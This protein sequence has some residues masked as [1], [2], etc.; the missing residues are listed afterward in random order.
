MPD[1]QTPALFDRKTVLAILG[2]GLVAGTIDVGAA[3]L[4]TGKTPVTILQTIAG[5]LF[6]AKAFAGGAPVAAL[7]LVLQWIMSLIIAAIF[8]AARLRAPL[9]GRRWASS[10]LAYGVAVFVVMNF[11]VVPLSAW[12]RFP[13]FTPLSAAENLL[14]M[15][16]FGLIVAFFARSAG[17]SAVAARAAAQDGESAA[18]A[19][20]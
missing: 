8:V 6:A 18:P 16:L 13:R 2:G 20:P 7:G 9:L 19:K 10:G 4:I 1:A 14:A 15:L 11:V 12:R 3:C 5:G 17:P